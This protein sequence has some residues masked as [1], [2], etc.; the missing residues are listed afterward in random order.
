MVGEPGSRRFGG[1]ETGS[2][3][4]DSDPSPKELATFERKGEG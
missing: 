4:F 1:I 2:Y 3:Q